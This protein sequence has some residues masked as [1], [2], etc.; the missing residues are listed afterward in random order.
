MK[1]YLRHVSLG[2]M[3]VNESERD[4]VI[5]D[6]KN[7]Q[8]EL[9]KVQ[10]SAN[11][12]CQHHLEILADKRS[13]QWQMSS[14]EALHIIN[15]FEKSKTLH[16]KH[17][18]L[19]QSSNKGTLRSL[20]VPAPI[21][22]FKNNI[23]DPRL[24]TNIMDSNL[25]FNFLLK[26]NFDH[27]IQSKD[28]MFTNGSLLKQCSCY[29]EGEGMESLLRGLI[30]AESME[31]EYPQFG[32][33]GVEFIKALRYVKDED[34]KKVEPFHWK[35]GVEEYLKVFNKTKESTA[36]GPSGIHMSHWKAA[37]ERENIAQVHAFFMWA[38]FEFG[39]SYQRWEQSWHCMIKK[40][41]QPL[42]PK[43]RIV[44]LFEGDF[45]AGLK[46]LI[47]RKMMAHMNTQDLH[48]PEMFG[49]RTGK[50][51]PEAIINL[52][53][54]FDHNRTWKLPIA[55]LFNDAIG[56]YDRIIPTLCKLAMRARGCPKGIAQCHTITQKNMIHRIQIATGI[57]DGTIK[58]ALTN[59]TEVVGRTI[60]PY[61]V[62]QEELDKG[63]ELDRSL[64]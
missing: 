61:K 8:L 20:M 3:K 38:A 51:A 59:L 16:S 31:Q 46:Y 24:Y 23:K 5:V 41:K 32:K 44:Q 27:L 4:R 33:E 18:R 1:K 22:G 39:F 56:C 21:T 7:A 2:I 42:L 62:E 49:S 6:L 14:S 10:K 47:G 12:F 58:F 17:C 13:H 43:L 54:L 35:F 28:S 36:C 37:C 64:G 50:T 52:Q 15:K 19:L 9:R 63:E 48:D 11:L 40:L 30:D 60:K 55:I 53:L 57:S 29:G 25:M 34:G 26:R 45:N